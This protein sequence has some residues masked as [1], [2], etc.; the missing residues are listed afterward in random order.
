MVN[1][2][3]LVEIFPSPIS[4]KNKTKKARADRMKILCRLLKLN[5]NINTYTAHC[6]AMQCQPM[7]LHKNVEMKI[8]T[9]R[10]DDDDE[11]SV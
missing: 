2:F 3:Y 7:I 5:T 10:D 4:N 1:G 6:K 9:R 11:A 8:L